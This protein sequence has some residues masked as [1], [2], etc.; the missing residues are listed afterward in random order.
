MGKGRKNIIIIGIM[1]TAF[2]IVTFS[3][4]FA[5]VVVYEGFTGEEN[6]SV[7]LGDIYMH[8][9][10]NNQGITL[11]D[12]NIDFSFIN[13]K[14]LNET[15]SSIL[16]EISELEVMRHYKELSDNKNTFFKERYVPP[17]KSII[18]T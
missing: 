14:Y 9:D 5:V 3:F 7:V 18:F 2:L 11:T 15:E 10:E 1:L 8:Y 6:S 13:S 4:T 17:L 16:P 12:E